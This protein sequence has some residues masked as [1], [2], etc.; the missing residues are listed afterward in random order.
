MDI[1]FSTI[2][3]IYFIVECARTNDFTLDTGGEYCQ[4]ETCTPGTSP[5][6]TWRCEDS[7]LAGVI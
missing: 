2:C 1:K 3:F 5:G 7:M 4:N 6:P